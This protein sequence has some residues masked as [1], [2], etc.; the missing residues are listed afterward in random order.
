[1]GA[2][3]VVSREQVVRGACRFFVRHG[4]VDMAALAAGLAVSRAT[5]YRVAHSRDG[6]LA[7][8]LWTLGG[9]VLERARRRCADG[10]AAGGVDGVLRVT[11]EFVAQVNSAA[12]FRRFLCRE[13]GTAARVLLHDVHRRAV[14][15]QRDILRSVK[16]WPPGELD[17][18]AYLYVRLVESVL[19]AE[20]LGGAPVDLHLA[21]RAARSLLA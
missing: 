6:L 10:G 12:P 18:A 15:A 8:A 16:P 20:L 17:Q 4:S 14:A 1:M 5:L 9:R 3:R 19:Y 7:D 2:R 11:R 13:P 21:E